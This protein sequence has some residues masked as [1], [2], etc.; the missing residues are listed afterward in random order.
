MEVN[1][2]SLDLRK[3]V[4]AYIQKGHTQKET[5]KV[6]DINVSTVR[7]WLR[8]VEENKSLKPVPTPRRPH[9]LSLEK[10]EEYVK[11]H[12]D[13]F[14]HEIAKALG[15]KKTTVFYALKKLGYKQKKLNCIG[16][17]VK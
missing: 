11:E 14:L 6:F 12:P 9:K 4:I 13:A 3:K 15:S 17:E 1:A 5:A 7:R 8:L 2:Y 16:K 10:L